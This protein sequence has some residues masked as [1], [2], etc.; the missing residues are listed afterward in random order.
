[1]R[2]QFTYADIGALDFIADRRALDW[3]FLD[4][5]EFEYEMIGDPPPDAD[6]GDKRRAS[7]RLGFFVRVPGVLEWCPSIGA[8]RFSAVLTDERLDGKWEY[9]VRRSR[10]SAH[11]GSS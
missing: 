1:M 10:S 3:W 5:L 7:L 6:H 11:H 2:R 8:T 9:P 4:E